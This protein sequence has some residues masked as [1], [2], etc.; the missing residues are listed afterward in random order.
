LPKPK[1]R[2]KYLP[3]NG[4]EMH[5][6]THRLMGGIYEVRRSYG[7]RCHDVHATF[8][9]DGSEIQ[10]FQKGGGTY[11][12]IQN[13]DSIRPQ[14]IARDTNVAFLTQNLRSAKFS[15]GLASL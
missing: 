9:E 8:Y 1:E 11:T 6:Q 4:K 5:I 7:L 14:T 15:T 12:H 10:K 3:R 13:G 2:S